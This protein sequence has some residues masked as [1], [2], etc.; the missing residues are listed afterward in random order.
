MLLRITIVAALILGNCA[1]REYGDDAPSLPF[2]G[3]LALL[4]LSSAQIKLVQK[5]I[6]AKSERPGVCELW[7]KLQSRYEQ[8]G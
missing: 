1:E 7:T 8:S 4:S 3:P 5:G 2:H 6:A